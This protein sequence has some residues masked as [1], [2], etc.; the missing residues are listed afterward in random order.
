MAKGRHSREKILYNLSDQEG[1]EH[2]YR[3]KEEKKQVRRAIGICFGQGTEPQEH[4][5]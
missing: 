4:T 2:I 1:N 3:R 5:T